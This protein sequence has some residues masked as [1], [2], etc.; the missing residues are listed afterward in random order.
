MDFEKIGD[1]FSHFL[2]DEFQDTSSI[3][4]NNL[5]PLISN[6]I[7]NINESCSIFGDGKQSIYRWRGSDVNQFLHLSNPKERTISINNTMTS[8]FCV[9][10]N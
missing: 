6:A 8:N 9:R 2:I 4:W 1:R 10:I 7:A 5:F 3:Q